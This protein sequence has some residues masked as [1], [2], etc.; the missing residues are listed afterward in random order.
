ML[1]FLMKRYK[2]KLEYNNME[3]LIVKHENIDNVHFQGEMSKLTK[4]R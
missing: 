4:C 3:I 2:S 1:C